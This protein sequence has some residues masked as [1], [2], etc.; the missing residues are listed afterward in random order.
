MFQNAGEKGDRHDDPEDPPRRRA[1]KRRGHGTYAND[2]PAIVGTVGRDT[3]QVRL[4]V[5]HH[6]DREFSEASTYYG[7]ADALLKRIAEQMPLPRGAAN[8]IK[9]AQEFYGEALLAASK[10]SAA[11]AWRLATSSARTFSSW[12]RAAK[13]AL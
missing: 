11:S 9:P 10:P 8:P 1:N 13:C 7:K 4:L 3:H 2:R 12:C 5:V 6:T